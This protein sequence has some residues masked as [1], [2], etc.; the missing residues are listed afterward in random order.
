MLKDIP[1]FHKTYEL[2]LWLYPA[3]NKF[4]K[5]QR[6]VLGQRIEQK[7]LRF[8]ELVI[9]ANYARDKK[10]YLARAGIELDVLRILIRLTKDLNFLSVRQYEFVSDYLNEIGKMLGGWIKSAK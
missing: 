10:E 9:E 8:L 6:F 5:S 7:I 2:V 3:V 4:P 1:I